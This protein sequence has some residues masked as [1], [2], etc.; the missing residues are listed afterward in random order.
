[1]QSLVTLWCFLI[2]FL[3][4]I[5]LTQGVRVAMAPCHYFTMILMCFMV[6]NVQILAVFP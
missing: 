5:T 4:T 1:M 6:M 2:S 3:I